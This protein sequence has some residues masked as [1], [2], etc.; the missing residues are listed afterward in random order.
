MT[1]TILEL[2]T[3]EVRWINF[4]ADGK[5][6][7]SISANREFTVWDVATGEALQ[8]IGRDTVFPGRIHFSPDNKMVAISFLLKAFEAWK[9]PALKYTHN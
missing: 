1:H 9:V 3:A 6:I 8:K 5:T 2:P 7:V 4:S